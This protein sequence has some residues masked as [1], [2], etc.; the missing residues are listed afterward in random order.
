MRMKAKERVSLSS[1]LKRHRK[2]HCPKPSKLRSFEKEKKK[3]FFKKKKGLMATWEDLDLSS[4]KEEDQMKKPFKLKG[5]D[6]ALM[7][8]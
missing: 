6:V 1:K 8:E 7:E 2:N 3:S 4:S 5:L